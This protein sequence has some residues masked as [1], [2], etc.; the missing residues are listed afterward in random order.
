MNV[1]IHYSKI[2]TKFRRLTYTI[3]HYVIDS[4][5]VLINYE[6]IKSTIF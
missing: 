2:F 3:L 1:K 4:V 5:K 6:M